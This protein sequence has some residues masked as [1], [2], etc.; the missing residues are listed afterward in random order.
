MGQEINSRL[1]VAEYR[2]DTPRVG[3]YS[4]L[5]SYNFKNGIFVSKD[6]IIGTGKEKDGAHTPQ[7]TYGRGRGKIYKDRYYIPGM[8]NVIDLQ[9]KQ[10]IRTSNGDSFKETRGDTIIF[11]RNKIRTGKGYLA[12]NLKSGYYDFIRENNWYRPKY[13]TSS[14]D[15]KYYLTISKS[16][17]PY[18]V[19]LSDYEGNSRVLVED[20]KSGPMMISDSQFPH[21]ETVWLN[22]RSFL[23]VIHH[24]KKSKENVGYHQVDLR[25]YDILNNTDTLF[26]SIDSAKVGLLNGYFYRNGINQ[27]IYKSSS[28]THYLV[29]TVGQQLLP[30]PAFILSDEFSYSKPTQNTKKEGSSIYR[31]GIKIGEIWCLPPVPSHHAIAVEYGDLGSNLG[32]PKGIK[33]WTTAKNDWITFDIPWINCIVGWIVDESLT[34]P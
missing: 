32:Y 16:Q 12:L 1:L 8:G 5:V 33:I 18:K 13:G 34:P 27:I 3:S 28:D 24:R 11:Y 25:K 4:Y 23:Y 2:I 31:K 7:V 30:Y 17:L 6:T 14:P 29:D 21:V 26:F 15:N 10:F 20:A 9:T 22:N 19:C